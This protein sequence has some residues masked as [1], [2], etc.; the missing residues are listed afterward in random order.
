MVKWYNLFFVILLCGAYLPTIHATPSQ[1]DINNYKN[2][3]YE[4]CNKQCYANRESCFAQSR[5]LARNRA[6]WQSMDLACFQQKNAC[7]SQCQLILSRPY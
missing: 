6:E 4:T 3:E 2:M 5:N 7:V 1:A